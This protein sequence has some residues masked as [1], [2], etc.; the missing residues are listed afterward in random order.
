MLKIKILI[1]LLLSCCLAMAAS[2]V[3]ASSLPS[4]QGRVVLTVT[5]ALTNR[6]TADAAE[7]DLA[8]L[9]QLPQ[10]KLTTTTPWTEGP[11]TFRGV[12]LRDL[13]A[14]VGARGQTLM[15]RALNDYA[16]EF[17]AADG[18]SYEVLLALR[19]NGE[20]MSVRDKGPIWVVYPDDT[21]LSQARDRMIWQLRSLAV[22]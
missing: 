7:F 3:A 2:K 4:P 22:R 20:P 6:N 11:Q 15:A 14:A 5:G 18:T 19:H 10:H 13:L 17:P 8:M 12:L 1:G 9:E 21:G 16:I